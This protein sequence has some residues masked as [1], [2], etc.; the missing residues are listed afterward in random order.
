MSKLTAVELFP[1]GEILAD[2]L[3]ARGW[4]QAEFAAIID[5]PAQFVNEV[6]AGKKEITRESAAQFEAALGVSAQFWLS[7]QDEYLLWKQEQDPQEQE[8]L[9]Q[10]H[11]RAQL[12]EAVPLAEFRKR[13]YITSEA[14]EEQEQEILKFFGIRSLGEIAQFRFAAR[15]KSH[16]NEKTLLQNL[17]V[18]CVRAAAQDLHVGSYSPSVLSELYPSLARSTG[19]PADLGSIQGRLAEV[20]VKIVFVE[21]FPGGKIDGCA[22]LEGATPVI[23]I[24]GRVSTSTRFSSPSCTSLPTFY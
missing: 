21:A 19:N 14:P 12:H 22:F 16:S 7:L 20:G 24:S 15:R 13:G 3:E 6:I 11:L 1:P 8:K 10:V 23:G 5:R 18:A 4:T 2:E 17:W 9:N